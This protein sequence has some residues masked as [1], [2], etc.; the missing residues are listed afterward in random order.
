MEVQYTKQLRKTVGE[1]HSQ[2]MQHV[3]LLRQCLFPRGRS[4]WARRESAAIISSRF[5]LLKKNSE[6]KDHTDF[7][8]NSINSIFLVTIKCA[9]IVVIHTSARHRWV[10]WFFANVITF[11]GGW[12]KL[13]FAV[14]SYSIMWSA[15]TRPQRTPEVFTFLFLEDDKSCVFVAFMYRRIINVRWFS[16]K[17]RVFFKIPPY[18]TLSRV[19]PQIGLSK[20]QQK[21]H[22]ASLQS[23]FLKQYLG[24]KSELTEIR[25]KAVAID[26]PALRN[27]SNRCY[28]TL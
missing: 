22:K 10:S 25:I 2:M 18:S 4:V 5:A 12:N 24:S 13:F 20:Y 28:A 21:S 27:V 23:T 19:H 8:P 9:I 11:N 6:S 14:W 16:S 1:G 7:W 17:H 26:E 3:V 15:W